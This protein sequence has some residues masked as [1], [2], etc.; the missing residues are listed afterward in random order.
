MKLKLLENHLVSHKHLTIIAFVLNLFVTL[1]A[2]YLV[3]EVKTMFVFADANV[4]YSL[5]W[6]P[7]LPAVFTVGSYYHWDYLKRTR[8]HDPRRAQMLNAVLLTASIVF[9]F[10]IPKLA[11]MP[12]HRLFAF[13]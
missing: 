2:I 1:L 8:N 11:F 5:F 9:Y 4:S 10:L 6:L 3:G 7:M 13:N 12:A